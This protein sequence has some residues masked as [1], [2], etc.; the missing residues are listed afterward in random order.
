MLRPPSSVKSVSM[1]QLW[2]KCEMEEHLSLLRG[3]CCCLLDGQ[4]TMNTLQK[5][6]SQNQ[7]Q[8]EVGMLSEAKEGADYLG[9]VR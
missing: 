4:S 7:T 8:E 5:A 2:W 9:S 3:M 1:H 6:H